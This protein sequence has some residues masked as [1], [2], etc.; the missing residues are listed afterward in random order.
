MTTSV[1]AE[2]SIQVHTVLTVLGLSGWWFGFFPYIG[3]NHPN[4]IILFRGVETTSQ[5]VVGRSYGKIPDPTITQLC[6][7]LNTHPMSQRIFK[8]GLHTRV[9]IFIFCKC[10]CSIHLSL[11]TGYL[12]PQNPVDYHHFRHWM[13]M[14]WVIQL[15]RSVKPIL[16]FQRFTSKM[17]TCHQELSWASVANQWWGLNEKSNCFKFQAKQWV[18]YMMDIH[19]WDVIDHGKLI[20]GHLSFPQYTMADGSWVPQWLKRLIWVVQEPWSSTSGSIGVAHVPGF[21]WGELT[22]TLVLVIG[23]SKFGGYWGAYNLETCCN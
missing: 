1:E 23:P 10:P 8:T 2:L 7:K 17:H 22:I 11:K 18:E 5:L 14:I 15:P 16:G 9:R 12:V 3:N 4:W 6:T 20:V 19:N 21:L 13:A